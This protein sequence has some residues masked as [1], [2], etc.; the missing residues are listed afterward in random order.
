[1]CSPMLHK[2]WSVLLSL[3]CVSRVLMLCAWRSASSCR[4]PEKKKMSLYLSVFSFFSE[5]PLFRYF[6]ILQATAV[7]VNIST[8]LHQEICLYS[9][10]SL[11][12]PSSFFQLL[13]AV[14]QPSLFLPHCP[15]VIVVNVLQLLIRA[16]EDLS[17][18]QPTASVSQAFTNTEL[19]WNCWTV[20]AY[21]EGLG[22]SLW[23]Y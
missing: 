17:R 13:L 22:R 18:K 4:R 5:E 16:L 3:T 9:V 12:L 2:S 1:M 15:L 19:T 8:L 23:E 20:V 14:C 10:E 7:F 11:T 21:K 6:R